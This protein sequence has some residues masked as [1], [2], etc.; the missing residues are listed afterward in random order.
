MSHSV[1]YSHSNF[2]VLSRMG[3]S[4]VGRPCV[5]TLSAGFFAFSSL[6]LFQILDAVL[7]YIGVL[8][9]GVEMEGNPLIRFLMNLVGPLVAIFVVKSFAVL[10]V[11]YL[12]NLRTKVQWIPRAAKFLSLYYL[13][14]AILPWSFVFSVGVFCF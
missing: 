12:W 3:Q 13:F 5:D 10:C 11:V 14:F 2:S 8:S 9:F 1:R 6:L 7:T 4:C